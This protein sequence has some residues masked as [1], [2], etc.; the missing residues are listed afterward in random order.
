[1]DGE[2]DV[3]RTLFSENG[4]ILFSCVVEFLKHMVM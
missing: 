1:M 3:A 4:K 2:I